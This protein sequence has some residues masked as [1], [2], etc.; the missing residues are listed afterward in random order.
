MLKQRVIFCLLASNLLL[1]ACTPLLIAGAAVGISVANDRRSPAV[2][3]DDQHIEIQIR[4]ELK[5][6][7]AL[8]DTT[9]ISVTSFNHIVLLTG[10]VRDQQQRSLVTNKIQQREGISRVHN[11]LIIA[12]TISMQ[13]RREDAWLTTKVKNALLHHPH[14]NALQIKVVTENN[15]VFLMGM[16][17]QAEGH[18]AAQTTQQ[19]NGVHAVIKV[20]EYLD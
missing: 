12:E 20:F 4:H 7:T 5:N 19:V 17:S 16:V 15:T 2:I 1:Q 13:S 14:L 10:Q 6:L 18:A 3:L 8:N 11:E 9:H